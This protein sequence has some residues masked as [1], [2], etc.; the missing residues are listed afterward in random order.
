MTPPRRCCELTAREVAKRVREEV[1]L[2][3]LMEL[4]E[5]S[6][7]QDRRHLAR[8]VQELI[9]EKAPD[10]DQADALL[11]SYGKRLGDEWDKSGSNVVSMKMRRHRTAQALQDLLRSPRQVN[12]VLAD[13][14]SRGI[15][16]SETYNAARELGV[17]MRNGTWKLR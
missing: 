9:R 1:V 14:K 5:D 16:N 11:S 13:M 7:P 12:V 10:T 17:E 3:Q 2:E 15:S 6:D 8:T 4:L